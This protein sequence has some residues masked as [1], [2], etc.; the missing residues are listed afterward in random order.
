MLNVN[1][2]YYQLGTGLPYNPQNAAFGTAA[3]SLVTGGQT[4]TYDAS[5]ALR[6]ITGGN[7]TNIIFTAAGAVAP[8]GSRLDFVRDSAGRITEIDSSTGTQLRYTYDSLGNL[9]SATNESTQTRARYGYASPGLLS[10]QI[11]ATGNGAAYTYAVSGNLLTTTALA[12]NIGLPQ[13]FAGIATTGAI[14][15]GQS[16]TYSL[17]LS[18]Q[19]LAGQAGGAL[20]LGFDITG[21]GGLN[22]AAVSINGITPSYVRID[23]GHSIA[24]YSFSTPGVYTFTLQGLANTAGSF[25]LST[26]VAGDVLAHNQVTGAD[27][28]ALIA[29][30]GKTKGSTGYIL[31]A[32]IN[33]DGVIDATDQ[34]FLES[35][36]G[37]V[38]LQPPVATAST[39]TITAYP[40]VTTTIDLGALVS[41]P[42]GLPLAIAITGVTGGTVRPGGTSHTFL[43]TPTVGFTGNAT[44][45]FR[46]DD[47]YI[48]S[49][50]ASATVTVPSVSLV[51]LSLTQVASSLNP[52]DSTSLVLNGI[53]SDGTTL[54]LPTSGVI[55]ATTNSG[56]VQVGSN[57]AIAAIANGTAVVTATYNGLQAGTAVSVGPLPTVGQLQFFPTAY[58]LQ[59]GGQTRQFVVDELQFDGTVLDRSSAA[60]GTIY[61]L[62]SASLGTITADGLFTSGSITGNGFV[63]V[64]YKGRTQ[65]VPIEIAAP[66]TGP[67]T[68]SSNGGSTQDAGGQVLNVPS[69]ALNANTTVSIAS[70]TQSQLS[71]GMPDDF[72]FGEAF[73]I[74]FG[75]ASLAQPA[76]LSVPAPAG[77]TPGQVLYLFR[78]A[79][80]LTGTNT[81]MNAWEVVDDLVVGND[82]R[83]YTASP[84]FAG[85]SADGQF[86]VGLGSAV[87]QIALAD[88]SAGQPGTSIQEDPTT[89]VAYFVVTTALGVARIP[90]LPKGNVTMFARRANPQG[91]VNTTP[92]NVQL[93]ASDANKVVH[94]GVSVN[95]PTP[96]DASPHVT[97][98]SFDFEQIAVGQFAPVLTIS[99]IN[100]DSIAGSPTTVNFFHANEVTAGLP[101]A[102]PFYLQHAVNITPF[103][104]T[105]TQLKLLIPQ[106]VA[107]ASSTF[108]I[109]R[110]VN[111]LVQ[112]AGQNATQVPAPLTGLI[113]A[114]NLK[115]Q[116]YVVA[117]NN[118]AGATG[119]GSVS[120]IS[121][122]SGTPGVIAQISVGQGAANVAISPDGRYAYVTN[123]NEGTISI[124]DLITLQEVSLDPTGNTMQRIETPGGHPFYIALSADGSTGMATDRDSGTVWQFTT[125]PTSPT[126]RFARP[127]TVATGVTGLTG[128]TFNPTSGQPLSPE[129]QYVYIASP[130]HLSWAG[131][132]DKIG[133]GY[134]YVYNYVTHQVVAQVRTG[135]KPFGITA[136][137]NP[138]EIAVAVR[139][140]EATGFTTITN[141]IFGNANAFKI[142]TTP[143]NLRGTEPVDTS[144]NAFAGAVSNGVSLLNS[145]F[146]IN[147]AES[148]VFSPDNAYAFVLFHNTFAL[149]DAS[150]DPSF[151][152]GSNIGIL[153]NPLGLN[154][155][156]PHWVGATREMPYGFATGIT[157]DPTGQ[158]LMA[159][160]TG[161]NEIISYNI[162]QLETGI[163]L[164]SKYNPSAIAKPSKPIEDYIAELVAAGSNLLPY[165]Q[166]NAPGQFTA[167]PAPGTAAGQTALNAAATTFVQRMLKVFAT[168]PLMQKVATG[169]LPYGIASG[170]PVGDDLIAISA[171]D[172]QNT[173]PTISDVVFVDYTIT[174]AG[175]T[176]FT[177]GLYNTSVPVLPNGVLPAPTQL[178]TSI[179][180]TSASDLT[181]GFHEIRINITGQLPT[182]AGYYMVY[183]DP[184]NHVAEGNENNNSASFALPPVGVTAQFGENDKT[185]TIFGTFI[186]SPAIPLPDAFTIKFAPEIVNNV[187]SV[188]VKVNGNVINFGGKSCAGLVHS[189]HRCRH[190][191]G[192][193]KHAHRGRPRRRRQ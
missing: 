3:F 19:D 64:I 39:T 26:F 58:T 90:L 35:N 25:S 146:D 113:T 44:I 116:S 153:Q 74:S 169:P 189:Q 114:V 83:A 129:G 134:V 72:T 105:P 30:L 27:E 50:P 57:G 87:N 96:T 176:P 21:T 22:P 14:T 173:D 102:A 24:L 181:P 60:S 145:L 32:D 15:A 174:G 98:I 63:T 66:V 1:G 133:V 187:A 142:N 106:N 8:D 117:V 179:N 139:G 99:G 175:H 136:T 49:A 77:T 97:S 160:F 110:T 73:H 62:S 148:I 172:Q 108:Q 7:S 182:S 43:F 152:S 70:L 143:T 183:L 123:T 137:S 126:A 119:N 124:I 156:A 11:P 68:V 131:T 92:F 31:A 16:A 33:R 138:D 53:F 164:L 40:G 178:E 67:I 144:A 150:R 28:T 88:I 45:T 38:A 4:Y 54:A 56:V 101:T 100:L 184:E 20:M 115:P 127:F 94:I 104:E 165:F 190:P 107:I 55:F 95:E 52:G 159:T 17:T 10:T 5:G 86:V 192:G 36:L 76:A 161:L 141:T 85:I 82:G 140:Q 42:N 128:I 34:T 118:G 132:D 149:G 81:T 2:S 167:T 29:A 93:N 13:Q 47:G 157:I 162:F 89:G 163:T 65:V 84:P 147:S 122:L 186:S 109:T 18:A 135:A 185:P 6:G 180:V 103:S 125:D 41:D 188:L 193:T 168:G 154:G 121:T 120:I 158:F 111:Q 151:G 130:Y 59:P 191:Q 71:L 37:F 23:A 112:T 51:G 69:G 48:F 155:T 80:L 91:F 166:A 79:K 171:T 177:I 46:A 12:G 75:G 170:P 9:V 78:A 61:I